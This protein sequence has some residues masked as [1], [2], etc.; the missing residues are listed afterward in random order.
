MQNEFSNSFTFLMC[1]FYNLFIILFI[2]CIYTGDILTYPLPHF[3]IPPCDILT[4]PLCHFDTA[5]CLILTSPLIQKTVCC[6]LQQTVFMLILSVYYIYK[7]CVAFIHFKTVFC[8][9]L[10]LFNFAP[11]HVTKRSHVTAVYSVL[12]VKVSIKDKKIRQ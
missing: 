1:I 2:T 5:P 4:Y 7:T 9:F 10:C 12:F 3:D 8:I 6:I 11:T